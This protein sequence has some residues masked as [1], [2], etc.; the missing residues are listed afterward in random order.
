MITKAMI[1]AH[2]A[3]VGLTCT[4][5]QV[6]PP[7]YKAVKARVQ[8]HHKPVVRHHRK[9]R[10]ANPAPVCPPPGIVT[11]GALQNYTRPLVPIDTVNGTGVEQTTKQE[12]YGHGIR[13]TT[14]YSTGV[15]GFYGSVS[16]PGMGSGDTDKP[17]V[18]VRPTP[19]PA[20]A[21]PE[22]GTWA[23]MLAGFVMV[24]LVLRTPSRPVAPATNLG[25]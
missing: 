24:G 13:D 14:N 7:V 11:I 2:A 10:S 23:M 9:A 6:A 12:G 4:A 25:E 20:S 21:L 17:P 1:L 19:T 16:N 15:G 5:V 18:V 3:T 22:P 8:G